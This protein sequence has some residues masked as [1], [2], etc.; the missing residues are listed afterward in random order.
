MGL[1]S[2]PSS[3]KKAIA[4]RKK[5]CKPGVVFVFHGHVCDSLSIYPTVCEFVHHAE[6]EKCENLYFSCCGRECECVCKCV[7][8]R[9]R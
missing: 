1:S 6:V 8:N 9:G 2:G 7:K 3:N 4:D 5:R